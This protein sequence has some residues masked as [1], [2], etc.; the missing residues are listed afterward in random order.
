[1][2]IRRLVYIDQLVNEST[3]L[4]GSPRKCSH[5]CISVLNVNVEISRLDI[6]DIESRMCIFFR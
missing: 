5:M 4:E 2:L 6:V 3:K 1:M